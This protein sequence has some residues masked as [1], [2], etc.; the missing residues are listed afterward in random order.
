MNYTYPNAAVFADKIAVKDLIAKKGYASIL[1]PTLGIWDNADDINFNELPDRFV[2]KA[3]HGSGWNFFVSDK[4]RTNVEQIRNNLRV[5]LGQNYCTI[6]G[7]YQY[8]DIRPRIIAE[9]DISPKVGELHDY[10]FFCFHGDPKFVQVDIDR[11][12]NH[13]RCFFDF[14]WQ[15]L[16][17]SI[18]YPRPGMLVQKPSNFQA[19][20]ELASELSKDFSFIRV[21][22][23]NADG[24]IFFGEFTFHPG[25]GFE[26]I[27][28]A[29]WDRT[30]GDYLTLP[31]PSHTRSKFSI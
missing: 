20:L 7:E 30:L 9:L 5:I 22:L 26:P 17:F 8:R 27:R 10:K 14:K 31:I 23:Y 18:L 3:S 16:P 11:H 19:M 12:T 24:K 13:R 6:G 4:A 28:P 1:V 25:G 21:D 29:R 15:L 2:V